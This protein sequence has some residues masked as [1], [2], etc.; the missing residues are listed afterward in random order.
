M[1]MFDLLNDWNDYVWKVHIYLTMWF[2]IFGMWLVNVY[3]Q[4]YMII[5]KINYW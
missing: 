1:Y 2:S 5:N 3:V 4:W